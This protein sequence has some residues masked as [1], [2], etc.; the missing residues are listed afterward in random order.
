MTYEQ[1]EE[2]IEAHD[3]DYMEDGKKLIAGLQLLEK[4]GEL[5]TAAAHDVLYCAGFSEDITEVDVLQLQ[6]YG[7]HLDEDS[8]AY[9]T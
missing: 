2:L 5:E 1:A 9:F 8:W 3:S 6:R 4:Y 7:F